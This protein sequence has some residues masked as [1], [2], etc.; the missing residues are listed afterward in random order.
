MK[1]NPQVSRWSSRAAAALSLTA[2]LLAGAALAQSPEKAPEIDRPTARAAWQAQWYNEAA[3]PAVI[4]KGKQGGP[5]SA[6]FR[7]QMLDAAARERAKWGT[8]IPQV[9]QRGSMET[10]ATSTRTGG[11][12][13]LATAST[14]TAWTSLGPTK[15]DVARNGPTSLA[16]TDAG[17]V[18]NVLIDPNNVAVIYAAFSGGGVWKTTNG[19]SS[20]A[21]ITE[22]VGSLSVGALAMDPSNSSVLYVGLGDAFHGTGIGMI[23]ST[24]GGASWTAPVFLGD[25]TVI[26]AIEVAPGSTSVVL[27]A[28]S[29]G[30]FRSTD[31]GATWTRVNLNTGVAGNPYAWSIGWTG[32]SNFV[33]SVEAN[34]TV[35]TGT[36]DGRIYRSTDN[37]ATWTRSNGPTAASGIG[38]ITIGVAASTRNTPATAVLYAMGAVPNP[39]TSSD[40]ADLFKSTNGGA[41]WTALGVSKKRYTKANSES[42]T[43]ATLMGGQ[44]WYN[45]MV[46]VDPTNDN[47][48]YFGGQLLVAKTT[49]GGRTYTQ[50]SNW[51]AQ[52]SLPYVHAD[53]HAGTIQGTTLIVG[54][55][56]GL[57]K[58]TDGGTTFTDALNIGITSHL[59]YS[60]GSSPAF[61]NTVI[62]G[63]QDN[64]TRVRSSVTPTTFN[65]YL[66]GDGFGSAVHR[67][68]GLMLASVYYTRIFK[69]TTASGEV[70]NEASI[71]I[72]ESNNSA[73]AP[74]Y[75][76][77][78]TWDGDANTVFTWVYTKVYKSTNF[79]TSWTALGTT[80]LSNTQAMPLYIRGVGVAPS[81]VN[82]IG[83]VANGGRVFLSSNGGTSW[84]AAGTPPNNGL[85]LSKIAFDPVNPAILYVAS[86][87]ADASKSHLW[88]SS[89]GGATFVA[90]DGAAGFPTGVPVNTIKVDPTTSSAL[91]VGTHLGVYRSTDGGTTWARFGS[92][93]PLVN[94]EDLYVSPDATMVRAAT[95]G[96][97]FWQLN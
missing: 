29:T 55:D 23:K 68:N 27:A 66:G 83:V 80:G 65:Q 86:V 10:A 24:D 2:A 89:D 28:T 3:S 97:G 84:A 19:G 53:F 18:S 16:K 15:A 7:R 25:S 17:R 63:F 61:P 92:G 44:G 81:D 91:Y 93:M 32:A 40:L 74:F 31:A 20:W 54:T 62:G 45:Q 14:G 88:K 79:A 47:T 34:P 12:T 82:R 96:R 41:T 51:L 87:A 43:L 78:V 8:M 77:V 64:G 5:W 33:V 90:I 26:N 94:V 56:G 67:S 6:D 30:V 49:D 37:G 76:G 95:F 60:V 85:S 46:L 4:A 69:S 50:K 73:T 38:R 13:T 72:T 42:S 58:S 75:T 36:T 11:A 70:F 22:S 48:A 52:F 21:P 1:H 71:G 57:F 35:T 59:I 9:R 39:T